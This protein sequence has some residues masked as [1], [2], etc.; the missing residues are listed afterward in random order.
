MS[1]FSIYSAE[2]TQTQ[3]HLWLFSIYSELTALAFLVPRSLV[4][5]M[6]SLIPSD[7]HAPPVV[8]AS[9]AVDLQTL[10]KL[11]GVRAARLP[12]RRRNR[13]GAG[14]LV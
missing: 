8:R 6:L 9:L 14:K 7:R 1:K 3:S 12:T 11:A 4:F 2:S 13:N 10:I 5:F